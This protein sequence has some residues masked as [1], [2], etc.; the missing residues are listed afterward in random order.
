VPVSPTAKVA[1]EPVN[2][3]CA[4]DWQVIK[5]LYYK[6][7]IV[8]LTVNGH[9]RGGLLVEGQ[10][11]QGFVPFSHVIDLAGKPEKERE[12]ITE[13]YIGRTL[14]LKVIEC[15]PE[16]GRVVFSERAAQSEPGKRASLFEN[17]K[18]GDQLTGQVTNITDFGVFIDL[19]GAEG[20]IHISELSWGRVNHPSEIVR[21]GQT[22]QVQVLDLSTERCRVALSLKRLQTN[23][24]LNAD[25]LF[26]LGSSQDATVTSVLS[27]GAF[28]KLS[29]GIEGLIHASEI[30]LH[31]G[32]LVKD[33][34]KEG[35]TIKVQV[36]HIDPDHQ[37]LGFTMGQK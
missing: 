21:I 8:E 32:Q 19:G 11:L 30:P 1:A 12:K 2:E 10:G 33:I 15:T 29:N 36:L 35:Q 3:K 25:Q 37:R 26:P 27:Y 13:G 34:L 17:I 28:A 24:W 7:Q 5:D 22:L 20:L 4:S 16:N 23:P 9:N 14:R 6:D 31:E 18:T